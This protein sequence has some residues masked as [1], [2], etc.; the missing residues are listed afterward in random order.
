MNR[1]I[2]ST[3]LI[4][5]LGFSNTASAQFFEENDPCRDIPDIR[6]LQDLE[7]EKSYGDEGDEANPELPFDLRNEAL[8]E[9]ALSLGARGGLAWRT[10]EIRHELEERATYLDSVYDFRRLLMSAPAGLLIEPPIISESLNA[11]VVDGGGLQADVSDKILSINRNARIVSAPRSWRFYLERDW[12][13]EVELPPDILRPRKGNKEEREDWRESV[14]EGWK[15]GID[16][17]DDI[18]QADLNELNRDYNGM[19]RY[20]ILLAQKMINPPTALLTDRGIAGGG[21]Q[22]RVGDRSVSISRLPE[23]NPGYETWRPANR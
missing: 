7:R 11:L 3:F 15:E 22:M 8:L 5:F 16:Q 2:I 6:I 4:A 9:A 19:I 18:F 21:N 13:E 23:L 12:G 20:R 17:A 1:I 10:C 14:L